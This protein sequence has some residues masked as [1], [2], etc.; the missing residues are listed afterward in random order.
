MVLHMA[1]DYTAF[2]VKALQDFLRA[3]ALSTVGR[4]AELVARL[5]E[6][7]SASTNNESTV[8]SPYPNSSLP[9]QR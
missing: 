9:P 2:T 8:N 3:R 4:K 5:E 6:S 7:D 1:V